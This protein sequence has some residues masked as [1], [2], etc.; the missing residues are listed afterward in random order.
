[1][2]D[3]F[4]VLMMCAANRVVVSLYVSDYVSNI[5]VNS[6]KGAP[7][8]VPVYKDCALPQTVIRLAQLDAI[9][10]NTS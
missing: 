8:F 1:M 3:T 7:H 6:G 10:S 9:L 5:V 2:S 4:N